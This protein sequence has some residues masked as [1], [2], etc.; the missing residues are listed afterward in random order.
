MRCDMRLS[1]PQPVLMRAF[2]I[3]KTMIQHRNH[4]LDDFITK[5]EFRYLL[6]YLIQ[7]YELWVG[8]DQI[9]TSHDHKVSYNEFLK[10]KPI[11]ESW[12]IDMSNPEAQWKKADTDGGGKILF[13][14]FCDWAI[15]N[16]VALEDD[17]DD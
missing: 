1:V 4:T 10:S 11:F 12:G 2:N 9:N 13:M 3:A 8:F 17:D 6:K 15:K 16:Q 5:D 14:E 7:Y